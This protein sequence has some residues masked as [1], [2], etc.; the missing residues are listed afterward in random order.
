M[1]KLRRYIS[2]LAIAILMGSLFGCTDSLV[3][4]EKPRDPNHPIEVSFTA[5]RLTDSFMTRAG[6]KTTFQE[7]DVI[8]VS[9]VFTLTDGSTEAQYTCRELDA[10]GEWGPGRTATSMTWPVEATTGSFTAYYIPSAKGSLAVD[11]PI[12]AVLLDSIAD[13]TD[14]LVAEKAD[15]TYGH[16]VNLSFKHLCTRLILQHV[17]TANAD[18]YWL[19][20]NND[21]G[22]KNAYQI[23]LDADKKLN[24][25][26]IT[27]G[28]FNDATPAKI[29]R[30]KANDEVA[31]YLVPGNYDNM[32]LNYSYYRPYLQ[33]D[34]SKDATIEVI[35]NLEAHHSYILDVS[36]TLGAVNIET[37]PDWHDPEDDKPITLGDQTEIQAF[38]EAIGNGNDYYAKDESGN[39]GVQV[40]SAN[41]STVTLL[42]NVDFDNKNK[43]ISGIVPNTISFNGNHYNIMNLKDALFENVYGS[44]FDLGLMNVDIDYNFNEEKGDRKLQIGT[45]ARY[46]SG[47]VD[48]VRLKEVNIEFQGQNITGQTFDVGGLIGGNTTD[49]DVS[50]IVLEGSIQVKATGNTMSILN[51]GG[52]IGQNGGSI[53]ALSFKDESTTLNVTNE[54]K[55]TGTLVVGGIV[56]SNTGTISNTILTT[57]VDASN[58]K[59]THNYTGG[60]VGDLN[61]GALTDCAVSGTVKGGDVEG[62]AEM[63]N[64]SYAGGIAGCMGGATMS[65]CTAFNEVIGYSDTKDP[66]DMKAYTAGGIIGGLSRN[67]S[68]VNIKGCAVWA[69]LSHAEYIGWMAGV[70]PNDFVGTQS[71]NTNHS[72]VTEQFGVETDET[73]NDEP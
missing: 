7:G 12:E 5:E 56:G 38:L 57:T 32:K 54:I 52:V 58:G 22:L 11:E 14:P 10:N 55:G 44:V 63:N 34:A 45:L 60:L 40:L 64:L 39:Q 18:E 49:G 23:T 62:V 8:Q 66:V 68:S 2:L 65:T 1:T 6:A 70:W 35:K 37:E 33:F 26:F 50:N 19:T 29:A 16:A 27:F 43:G 59:G 17:K 24:F 28:T 53:S 36:K 3:N 47:D 42:R 15:V 61:A 69:K 72:S 9:A 48:N 51:L 13:D 31:F 67:E 25:E 73:F 30:R 46:S 20:C 21:G 71:D 41:G 4:D